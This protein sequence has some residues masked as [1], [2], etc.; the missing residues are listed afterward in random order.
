MSLKFTTRFAA[1][2]TAALVTSFAFAASPFKSSPCEVP[3]M[4]ELVLQQVNAV[5]ARGYSCGGQRFGS[6][7][8]VAWNGQ[9]YNAAT[10]HSRDMAE[11][12]YFSHADRRGGQA[13]HRAD[14]VGYKWSTVGENIAAG[15]QYKADTV[16]AGWLGSTAHCRNI[17]DPEY[18]EI[19][20][21]CVARPGT[22]Y[23]SYWTMVLG[24]RI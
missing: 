14:A 4:R 8:S 10:G 12:N 2:A 11:N 16:V 22:T 23:G 20:V 1:A 17:M 13:E 9:L 6:T 3:G 19:G 15:E 18:N 7:Q 24:R 5:R 21:A